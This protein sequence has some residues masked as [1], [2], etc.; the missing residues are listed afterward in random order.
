MGASALPQRAGLADVLA[1]ESVVR[2]CHEKISSLGTRTARHTVPRV[3]V[4]SRLGNVGVLMRLSQTKKLTNSKVLRGR[5]PL[6]NPA[7]PTNSK[8][9]EIFVLSPG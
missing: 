4:T 9:I 6:S 8:S 2:Q 5:R 3:K 7:V 1:R